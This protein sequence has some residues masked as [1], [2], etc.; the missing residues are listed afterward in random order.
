MVAR[1]AVGEG[2]YQLRNPKWGTL[3]LPALPSI[4]RPW[5]VNIKLKKYLDEVRKER[6]MRSLH[7]EKKFRFPH[8][9]KKC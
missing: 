5:A 9:H 3:S 2:V 4:D 6:L 7:R 1:G 8:L